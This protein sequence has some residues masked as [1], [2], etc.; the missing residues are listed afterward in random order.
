MRKRRV[1]SCF[2]I[3]APRGPL[4]DMESKWIWRAAGWVAHYT[5]DTRNPELRVQ[6]DYG[7]TRMEQIIPLVSTRPNYGGIRWWYLC[8]QCN[9]RV[10]TLHKPY[11]LHGFFCRRCHDLTYESSQRS[12]TKTERYFQSVARSLGTTTREARRWVRL[13]YS[14]GSTVHEIKRPAVNKRRDRRNGF[15]LTLT[16]N[17]RQEGLTL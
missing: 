1:E 7:G 17:A 4:C 3:G 6:F 14:S 12:G 15:A 10:A 13:Q 5:I 2:T 16:K 11:E 9:Q 8:P